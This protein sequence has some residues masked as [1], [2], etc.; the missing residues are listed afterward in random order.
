MQSFEPRTPPILNTWEV[1]VFHGAIIWDYY[2]TAYRAQAINPQ[3][4]A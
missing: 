3:P 2:A 4:F 1:P